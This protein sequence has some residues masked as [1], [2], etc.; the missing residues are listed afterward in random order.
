[1]FGTLVQLI[2]LLFVEASS[3][4]FQWNGAC[5]EAR[6]KGWGIPN[7]IRTGLKTGLMETWIQILKN[8]FKL[9]SIC[10]EIGWEVN[11]RVSTAVCD[12]LWRLC[13]SLGL[14]CNPRVLGIMSKFIPTSGWWNCE[15]S[16]IRFR[17]TIFQL[18][19]IW[20]K[21]ASFFSMTMQ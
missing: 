4:M 16:T 5:K 20:L 7:Y 14:K 13:H 18:E 15:W 19:V 10:I 8:W 17:S 21:K 12:K 3:E 6:R 2:H 11:Q 1:M 9:S